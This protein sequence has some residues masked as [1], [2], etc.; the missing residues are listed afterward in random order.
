MLFVD[1]FGYDAERRLSP[2][3]ALDGFLRALGIP[4]EHIPN[5]LQDLQRLYRSVL[6]AF[7]EQGRRILVVIDNASSADQAAAL[8]PTDGMT[9]VLITS[10]HTLDIYARLHDLNVLD[11]DASL[12]L[13]HQALLQA[14]G[15][16]DIRVQEAPEAAA[17]IV[18]L[19]AGLPLALRIAA[20][21]LADTPTRPLTS[22]AQALQTE[23]SR[24]DRLRRE[25]RAVRAAFDLSYQRLSD[26][27]AR[28]FRLCP[29]N[30]G[31][32]LSTESAA[33]LA[34]MD[35][36]TAEEILQDLNRAHLIETSGSAWG[37]WR[38]HD[39]VRL[40]ATDHLKQESRKVQIAARS[41][42]LERY[43][44][45]ASAASSHLAPDAGVRLP[46]SSPTARRRWSGWRT[47]G[48]TWSP[49]SPP[50]TRPGLP[51]Q[52]PA[53]PSAWPGS[54]NSAATS[55][56]GPPS[57]PPRWPSSSRPATTRALPGP[58]STSAS[59]SGSCDS[60]T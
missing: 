43:R 17:A 4:G 8:L 30:A 5:E 58:W 51:P 54:S 18:D 60:S 20:A 16:A 39:L 26:V 12:A 40:Y 19:C 24:M 29:L 45:M 28:L 33:A 32:D 21:L 57:P 22:L 36:Y 23:H 25:D 48:P 7:V 2:E 53:S 47:N 11:T 42:L 1:L 27:S 46:R 15:P 56:T 13:L 41:R 10:R 37:R 50:L 44:T 55:P 14:H 49:P 59:P 6:A 52:Q 3:R 31:P 35:D 34:D 38:M 9:A